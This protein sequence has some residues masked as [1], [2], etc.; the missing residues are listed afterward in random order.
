M[1]NRPLLCTMPDIAG[2]SRLKR[3][4]GRQRADPPAA[5]LPAGNTREAGRGAC[6]Y[7]PGI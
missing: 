6:H 2:G 3:F 7:G 4:R 1:K 5:A